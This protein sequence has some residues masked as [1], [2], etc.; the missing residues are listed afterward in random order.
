M[1]RKT[2]QP[3]ESLWPNE[4]Q[5]NF[6]VPDKQTG[7]KNSINV[8]SAEKVGKAVRL[9]V[10][11]FNDADRKLTCL[12]V[13]FPIDYVNAL[14]K[15][16]ANSGK[17]I[18]QMSKWWARRRSS[19]FRTL[20][21]AAAIEAPEDPTQAAIQVSS[22]Y[23]KN[24]QMAGSFK[25]LRVLD[26]FMGGG[27]TLVEGSRLGM[28]VH[29][30]D[31]NPVSWLI[32]KNEMACTDPEQA[33]ALFNHIEQ[34]VKPQMQPFTTTSCPRGHIGHWVDIASNLPVEV[35][36]LDFP[37][38]DRS[39]YRWEGPEVIYTFW[40]KHGSC[41]A[42][43]CSHRTPIFNSPVIAEK[44]L[45]TN[46]LALQCPG[47]GAGFHA[48]LGETRMAPGSERIVLSDEIP[49][50]EV[51]QDA[52]EL[53]NDYDKG[54]A[55]DT[56]G[57]L[58]KLQNL[59]PN[60]PAFACPHCGAFSGKKIVEILMRHAK[61]STKAGMRKK[62]DFDIQKKTVQMYLL[63][64]PEWL[65]GVSANNAEGEMG[66]WAGAT[67]EQTAA[68]YQL[69][70]EQ[71][72]LIE[73]R[74][75][76]LPDVVQ[77]QNGTIIETAKGTVQEDASFTCGLCGKT[78]D[79]LPATKNTGHTAAV[80]AYVQQCYCPQCQAEGY[81]YNGR[82]FKAV[83]P[84]D[85][86]RLCAAEIEWDKRKG[87]DLAEYWPKSEMAYSMRT[88]V[89]DPLPDHGYTHWW[90][91]FNARQL[92]IHASL[93]KAIDEATEIFPLDACEQALGVFQQYLRN[94]NMF[95]IWNVKADKM[96]PFFSEGNYNPKNNTIE[97]SV[98]TTLGR[99]NW[100][101]S[102]AKCIDALRWAKDPW[103]RE[104]ADDSA[105]TNS[106]TQKTGDPIIP[107][108]AVFCASSTDLS[109]LSDDSIDLVITDP[110]FGNNYY[111]A[112]LADFFYVWL[113]L[114][115]CKWYAGLAEQAYFMPER[116]PHSLEA[117][118]NAAEH[119][120]DREEFEK[121]PYI[122]PKQLNH[123]RKMAD[124]DTLQAK[125]PNPLYRPV[126]ASEFYSQTL[127]ACW[128]EAARLL[129]PGGLMA[130]TFHHNEVQAWID[131]LKALFEAG[132]LLVRTFPVISD[133]SKGDKGQFGSKKIQYDII[134]VCRKRLE[135]P[136]P[137][138]W[139]RMRR[140]VKE[141][142]A[143]L[144]DLLE[145]THG[146]SMNES[147][148]RVILRGKALEYYSRHFGQVYAGDGQLLDIRDALLG[149]NQILDDLLEEA[150]TIHPPDIAEPPSRLYLRL[151]RSQ[152]ELARDELHKMLQGTVISQSDLEARGWIR[153]DKKII[154]AVPIAERFAFFTK[155]GRNRK[156][157][158][159]DLD[160]AHFL[161]GAAM[162]NSGMQVEAELNNPN[163]RIKKSVDEILQWYA[164]IATD[165]I[166]QIAA[167]NAAVIVTKWRMKP[168]RPSSLQPTLFDQ[169]EVD[170]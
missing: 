75:K 120:D 57:R 55:D 59:L 83:S 50:T 158:R 18:Y 115:L 113:Q 129:K 16:E 97:N 114:P 117:I 106:V 51:N 170:D 74:G 102:A 135:E 99:G 104:A 144:K 76:V 118:D 46:Y 20:L 150:G 138:S 36:L 100:E 19:V 24:H 165:P 84:Q 134:H 65:Q 153:E 133:E 31:L 29:G 63:I 39:R 89:K 146:T 88:H 42:T 163:F 56:I 107:G 48:E 43:G 152:S 86:E 87:A 159:A 68:W 73:I 111:Y 108:A 127:G 34:T 82:Y 64:H 116:T 95:C 80:A 142:T 126:P 125:D 32:V 9:P 49:F 71:L 130:F 124:D 147:D 15:L 78:Q 26:C 41:Q 92:L 156:I 164:N 161:M 58:I 96:E 122:L 162:P 79:R 12:E 14:S 105:V 103:E 140:W 154:Y 132:F 167:K 110:P 151:F 4:I 91:L 1:S 139:A 69:R 168:D 54:T 35:N 101:S 169:L 131:V 61:P 52:A 94:Q 77:L 72:S 21:M 2:Q 123:I 85:V 157:I 98:F 13:N 22:Q 33:Q 112:D 23:Y 60:D 155:P 25:H 53:L 145:H 38:E 66:G 62:R 149:I 143:R 37:P 81:N 141:E 90:M 8:F 70:Q 160:Q 28:Q 121:K 7:K 17:P 109:F 40:A 27:T 3:E 136:T 47:C 67:A 137:V 45:S 93:L 11:D 148:L 166:T 30:V 128:T 6:S 44:S 5:L 119:P 10:P